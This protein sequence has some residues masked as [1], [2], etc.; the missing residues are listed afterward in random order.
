MSTNN[1]EETPKYNPKLDRGRRRNSRVTFLDFP[2]PIPGETADDDD[3]TQMFEKWKL[4]PYAGKEKHTGDSLLLFYAMLAQ[5]SPT[6]GACVQKLIKYAVG[7]RVTFARTVD[8][9]F[10]IGEDQKPLSN[11]EQVS[12]RDTLKEFITFEGGIKAFN[13][14]AAWQYK[15]NG[16]VFVELTFSEVLGVPRINLR[17]QKTMNVKYRK[18]KAGEMRV[19][20]ISPVWSPEYLKKNPP[21]FVPLFPNFMVDENKVQHTVFHLKHGDN[22]WYGRPDSESAVLY[23]FREVQDALYLVKQS[24]ANFV[25]QLIIEI[26]DDDPETSPAIENDDAEKNG[27]DNFTDR[28]EK[29]LTMK[30]DDPQSVLVTARPYGSRPMEVHQIKPNTKEN[31]YKVTGEISEQKVLRSHGCTLR[32]MGFDAANGF[33]SDA[34]MQDYIFNMQLV[35]SELREQITGFVNEILSQCWMMVNK[36][37]M[38]QISIDCKSPIQGEI[39]KFNQALQPQTPVQ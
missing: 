38:N 13:R 1:C 31:W 7:G 10:D 8:P 17:I 18:T 39:D 22:S 32:F 21:R 19:V 33:S 3:I 5:L 11:Q 29:N 9:D 35:I 20:A 37:E 24:A 6:H 12:F 2:N 34:F 4:V 16:N 15:T 36:P 25:G 30:S 28:F 14:R 26:E 27:F 23:M